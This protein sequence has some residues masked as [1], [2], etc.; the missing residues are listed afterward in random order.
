[1]S[2]INDVVTPYDLP[3]Q[4]KDALKSYVPKLRSTYNAEESDNE[5]P[6]D[7]GDETYIGFDVGESALITGCALKR[8]V[9]RKPMLESG[10]QARHPRKE[11]FTT[12]KR[13]QERNAAE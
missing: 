13:L 10:S 11:M 8:D 4:A 5:H 7:S 9:P 2:V 6:A 3:Y 1:M 12:L